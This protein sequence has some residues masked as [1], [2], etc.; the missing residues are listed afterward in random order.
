[1]SRFRSEA[2]AA[3]NVTA[4]LPRNEKLVHLIARTPDNGMPRTPTN[5]VKAKSHPRRLVSDANRM[6]EPS[7]PPAGTARYV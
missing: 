4:K 1:M 5:H 2:S 6:G 3:K 7:P